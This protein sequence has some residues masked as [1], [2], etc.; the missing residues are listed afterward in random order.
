LCSPES[1]DIF[2]PLR[3]SDLFL[4]VVG[5]HFIPNVPSPPSVR[6]VRGA[7]SERIRAISRRSV[8]VPS[9][10]STRATPIISGLSPQR[11]KTRIHR[12]HQELLTGRPPRFHFAC[13][14]CCRYRTAGDRD[15]LPTYLTR[16]IASLSLGSTSRYIVVPLLCSE[17]R[18]VP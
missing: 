8:G 3:A 4:L 14:Q 7:P 15:V 1:G 17:C 10:G 2:L 6:F 18:T 16:L 5:L 9:M 12:E 11:D 13:R